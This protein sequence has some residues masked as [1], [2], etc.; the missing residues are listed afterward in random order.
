V[1]APDPCRSVKAEELATA[2]WDH[3][4]GRLGDPAQLVAQF[5][6]CVA[7]DQNDAVVPAADEQLA[8]RLRRRDRQEAH[9]VDAYQAEVIGREEL[10]ERRRRIGQQRHA[11]ER[12]QAEQRQLLSRR[13]HTQAVL[14]R[15]AACAGRIRDRLRTASSGD[16]RAS[17]ELVIARIIVHDGD[18]EIRHVIPPRSPS[19]AQTSPGDA[20]GQW[21]SDGGHVTALPGGTQDLG[22]RGLDALMGIRDHQVHALEAAAGQLAQEGCP[23]GFRFRG[24]DG[25]DPRER[26]SQAHAGR[27]C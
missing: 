8:L 25:H 23:E 24:T 12:Q 17:L 7:A 26:R 11:L 10:A 18:L 22:R 2:V 16:K 6:R 9:L 13:H 1:R 15:L 4:A 19:P 27:R 21:R 3:R 20:G 5:A 14:G